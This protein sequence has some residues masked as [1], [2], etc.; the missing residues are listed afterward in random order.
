MVPVA[1]AFKD[2]QKNGTSSSDSLAPA[3]EQLGG[4]GERLALEAAGVRA[5]LRFP[6]ASST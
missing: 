1:H 6:R 4:I 5:Y 2:I 3:L